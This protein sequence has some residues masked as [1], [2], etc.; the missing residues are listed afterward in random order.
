MAGITCYLAA[1]T[2]PL[3]LAATAAAQTLP[4]EAV[5]QRVSDISGLDL[6]LRQV[7]TGLL[8]PNNFKELY[9]SPVDDGFVRI[10]GGLYAVFP[11]SVYAAK[12]DK[13]KRTVVYPVVPAGTVFYIG[14]P[15]G[16]TLSTALDEAASRQ[17]S[18]PARIEGRLDLRITPGL[19]GAALAAGP[20]VQQQEHRYSGNTTQP[21]TGPRMVL[22]PEYRAQRVRSLM[23]DAAQASRPHVAR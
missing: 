5:E 23:D 20:Q 18:D 21:A 15:P 14:P 19:M 6:S 9:R 3:L 4:L 7:Q 16:W 8:Q 12:K 22:D 2:T 13:Q 10:S 17:E 1:I 11:R